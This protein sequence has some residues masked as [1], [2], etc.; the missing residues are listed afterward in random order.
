MDCEKMMRLVKMMMR[1]RIEHSKPYGRAV[2][3]ALQT[4][5]TRL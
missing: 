5:L 4:V 3:Y 1:R 2:F